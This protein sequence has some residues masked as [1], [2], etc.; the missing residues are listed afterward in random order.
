MKNLFAMVALAFIS[1]SGLVHAEEDHFLGTITGTNIDLKIYQHAIA[2]SIKGVVVF[3]NVDE[4]TGAVDLS[5]KKDNQLIKAS[6]G[7]VNGKTGGTIHHVVDNKAIDTTIYLT[8]ID[9]KAQ[10]LSFELNGQNLDLSVKGEDFQNNHFINPTYIT[11]FNGEEIT[12]SVH[13]DKA[14]YGFSTNL[15]FMILGAY[16][17]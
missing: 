16:F 13:G 3:G 4:E 1:V 9:P 15:A 17:H 14:C 8:K 7:D 5:I 10:I 2:G 12:Y 6:F 11:K